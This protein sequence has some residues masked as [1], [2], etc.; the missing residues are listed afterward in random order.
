MTCDNNHDMAHC[1][2]HNAWDYLVHE[3]TRCENNDVEDLLTHFSEWHHQLDLNFTLHLRVLGHF[4]QWIPFLIAYIDVC[5]SDMKFNV[6]VDDNTRAT[7][8]MWWKTVKKMT[9]TNQ[10]KPNQT[11]QNKQ[12]RRTVI[13]VSHESISWEWELPHDVILCDAV[14]IIHIQRHIAEGH[15]HVQVELLAEIWIQITPFGRSSDWWKQV[16]KEG[17]R[18][19]GRYTYE[20]VGMWSCSWENHQRNLW[21]HQEGIKHWNGCSTHSYIQQRM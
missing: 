4:T 19:R 11:E 6:A 21:N 7:I 3:V 15:S 9:P 8:I 17:T 20:H 16:C 2:W 10:T 1:T 5:Q 18:E 13:R 12:W 14:A